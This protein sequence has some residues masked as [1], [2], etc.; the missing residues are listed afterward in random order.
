MPTPVEI[1]DPCMRKAWQD[2]K[3]VAE[4][5]AKSKKQEKVWKELEKKFNLD[6]GPSLKKWP[7][8]Y[9]NIGEMR[10]KKSQIETVLGKYQKFVKE[11]KGTLDKTVLLPLTNGI[12]EATDQLELRLG[13]A[14]SLLGQDEDLALKQAIKES[15]KPLKPVTV[16]RHPDLS[17]KIMSKAPKARDFV[18]INKLEIEVILSDDKILSKVDDNDGDMGQKIRDAADFKQLGKDILVAYVKAAQTVKADSTKFNQANSTFERDFETALEASV[19]R[20]GAELHRLAGVRTDYRNYKIKSGAQ[21]ALTITG[22]VAG[23]VSLGLAPFTGPAMAISAL[24]AVR[25]AVSTG[26]QIA[27]LSMEAEELI[28]RVQKNVRGLDKRYKEWSGAQIGGSEV[29]VTLVNAIAPTFFS[30]IKSCAGECDQIGDKINGIEVEAGDVSIK[31]NKAIDDQ[32]TLLKDTRAWIKA[33]RLEMNKKLENS[34]KSM[35]VEIK[36]N[37]TQVGEMIGEVGTLNSRLRKASVDQ[38]KLS[39]LIGEL[40]AKEPTAAK[41]A[42]VFVE[43]GS[44]VGFLVAANVGWPDAYDVAKT[45]K[46]I[47]DGIGNTV[48][49]ADGLKGLVENVKGEVDDLRG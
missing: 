47:S 22:T 36:K 34:F 1:S 14:I 45:A 21:L 15:K 32:E 20:A 33:N 44:S 38:K 18:E 25:G 10:S 19:G 28:V 3:K 27:L 6:L 29:G 35:L 9:P 17:A 2:A 49:V 11:Q 37:Q 7:S 5:K 42:E 26:K 12:D 8:S 41:F 13:L 16:F 23:A 30:T 40:S 48:G 31:L 24:G 43:L 46:A 39:K 4:T